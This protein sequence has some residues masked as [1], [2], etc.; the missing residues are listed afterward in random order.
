MKKN[1]RY[2]GKW[3]PPL[4][5]NPNYKGK[6]KPKLIHNPNYFNDEHPFQMMPIVC[7]YIFFY[8]FPYNISNN[9]KYRKYYVLNINI[10]NL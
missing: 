2:K 6:W 5:N 4:I 3:S 10:L 8:I 1:P 7:S 9:F